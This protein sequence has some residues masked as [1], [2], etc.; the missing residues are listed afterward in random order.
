M[1]ASSERELGEIKR[2]I[3]HVVAAIE[4][5]ADVGPLMARLTELEHKRRDIEALL[6]GTADRDVV[7]LHPQAAARYR[8]KVAEIHT[9]L[10][11]GSDAAAE[12]VA[13]V[14][15]LITTIRIIPAPRGQPVGLEIVG[16][17]AALMAPEQPQNAV[18]ALMVA[19]AGFSA[20]VTGRQIRQPVEFRL[21][22]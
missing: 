21:M 22:G 6:P 1:R 18:T 2:R 4:T 13:R 9:A 20:K 10:A 7:S 14:R 12:A 11:S 17:L 5:G 3:A 19:G 8:D 16:D 15:E